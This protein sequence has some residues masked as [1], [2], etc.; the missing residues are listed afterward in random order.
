MKPPGSSPLA[1]GTRSA[2]W[3]TRSPTGLIP[4]RA[5]NTVPVPS[6]HRRHGAHPRSRGEHSQSSSH[7]WHPWGS[8]PLA[9]GTPADQILEQLPS[10]LIP[11]RAGNTR[12]PRCRRRLSRAHPRSRGEH[13]LRLSACLPPLGSSPLARGTRLHRREHRCWLGLIPARAG[14]T[15]CFLHQSGISRAHPRSRGEHAPYAA[16]R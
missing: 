5:G 2:R 1:R 7:L 13:S 11:A 6:P 9:R 10:G 4:A 14:N 15:I 16:M 12:T 3:W 8:S